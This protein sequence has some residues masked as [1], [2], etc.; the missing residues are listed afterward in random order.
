MTSP[1][2]MP[3]RCAAVP[4]R[5]RSIRAPS[6]PS[7]TSTPTTR[8]PRPTVRSTAGRASAHARHAFSTSATGMPHADSIA[9]VPARSSANPST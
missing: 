9:F 3:A 1:A 5:T 7:A 6:V 4:R 2:R 8:S